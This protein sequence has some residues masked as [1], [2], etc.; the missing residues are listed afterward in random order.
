ML[1]SSMLS[2]GEGGGKEKETKQRTVLPERIADGKDHSTKLHSSHPTTPLQL[3]KCQIPSGNADI[4]GSLES[5][6]MIDI[7]Y[8]I[9]GSS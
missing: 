6:V 5:L 7:S 2:S 9:K 4:L 8:S 3:K 1:F